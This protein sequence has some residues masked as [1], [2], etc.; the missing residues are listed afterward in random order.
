MSALRRS[1]PG[2]VD[3]VICDSTAGGYLA[4]LMSEISYVGALEA[5]STLGVAGLSSNDE[6][7]RAVSDALDGITVDGTLEAVH[8]VWYGTMPYDLTAKTV[9]GANVQ[10]CDSASSETSP[11]MATPLITTA[12]ARRLARRAPSPTMTSTSSI[13]S[14]W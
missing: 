10:A 8:C 11:P 4:R 2:E 5:P 6:L 3:Y 9:S 7:C 14:Y 1:S 13:A 12:T